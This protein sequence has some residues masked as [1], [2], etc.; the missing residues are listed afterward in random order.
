MKILIADDHPFTLQGTKSFVESYG[1][2]VSD[3]CSNGISAL[4]L[5][6]L[7]T[8][9]IAILD[10]N[11]PGLDGLDVAKKVQESKLKTKII[12]LTMHK[13]MTIFKKASEYGIYGYILKEHAQTELEKCLLEVAKGNKYI[14]QFLE[15]D[16]VVDSKNGNDEIAKLTLSER[17]IIELITQQKTSKQIA[18]LLFL[19]EK[20]V[21]GHRSNIIEKLGLPKEKN[22]LLKWAILRADI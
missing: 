8:P 21:E 20:T 14:S 16:L 15:D 1:Y 12:L 11:M 7:H 6:Q 3:S 10:I 17:K 2:K 5:I 9:E 19:S 18:E 13:E 4:N 22:T